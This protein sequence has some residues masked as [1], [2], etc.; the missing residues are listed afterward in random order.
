MVQTCRAACPSAQQISKQFRNPLLTPFQRE[1]LRT[2]LPRS[3]WT[4]TAAYG[5]NKSI[6]CDNAPKGMY[7]RSLKK[8][9]S[10]VIPSSCCVAFAT[11]LAPATL[12]ALP[13]GMCAPLLAAAV[14]GMPCV[15]AARA[16]P[17][18][19]PLLQQAPMK[20]F[21]LRW[22]LPLASALA[23]PVVTAPDTNY[24]LSRVLQFPTCHGCAP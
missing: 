2:T 5:P 12:L 11:Q 17:A 22:A 8:M 14:L 10:I 16:T 4:K 18:S 15:A 21:A 9:L 3:G 23:Q 6:F 13:G 1:F 24:L 19:L 7:W 20:M